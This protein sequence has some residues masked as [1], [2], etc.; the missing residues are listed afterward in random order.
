[1]QNLLF[2]VLLN[3]LFSNGIAPDYGPTAYNVITSTSQGFIIINNLSIRDEIAISGINNNTAQGFCPSLNCDIIAIMHGDVCVGWSYSTEINDQIY[4]TVNFNDQITPNISN[5]PYPGD[6]VTL[7]FFDTSESIMYYGI[8]SVQ[9]FPLNQVTIQNINIQGDGEF[10]TENEGCPLGYDLNFDPFAGSGNCS[11]CDIEYFFCGCT[12]YDAYN[13]NPNATINSNTCDYAFHLEHQLSNGNN[14]ISFPGN[15]ENSDI[16]NIV[17][18]FTDYNEIIN[19]ILGQGVGMFNTSDGWSG[20]L[21]NISPYSGYWLNVNSSINWNITFDR[22]KLEKC[23][24]Y[25]HSS[26]N[27]LLS[28]KLGDGY[29]PTLE[30]LG[31]EEFATENYNF[32]L[33][34]GVGLFNT[35]MGWTGNLNYLKEGKGYWINFKN[36][37]FDFKWGMN[38]CENPPDIQS[39]EKETNNL[40]EEFNFHQSTEQAIYLI[41]NNDFEHTDNDILLAFNNNILVGSVYFNAE[42]IVLPVMGYDLTE[43]TTGYCKIGDKPKLKLYKSST[44]EIIELNI[45]LDSFDNLKISE[46]KLTKL[47]YKNGLTSKF[48]LKSV[49]PNPFNSST[50]INYEILE[51]GFVSIS[52]INLL[53]EKLSE[54]NNEYKKSGEY[55]LICNADDLTSGIYFLRIIFK[56]KLNQFTKIQKIALVK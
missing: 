54:I 45:E 56:S 10:I 27:N 26:G 12:D 47:K 48:M 55:N 39:L 41:H 35:N 11:L 40:P 43:E 49:Y 23:I 37:N 50:N 7:N 16:L 46:L 19:F 36:S 18:N 38:N 4:I 9:V 33:G 28:F 31:G 3:L 1:M 8:A 30:A 51:N 2:Y 32:I 52:I 53:G 29:A 25:E 6:S 22:G 17:N 15:F 44:D 34:Q 14:L 20:N 5:Y 42:V 21:I 13:Y 24:T